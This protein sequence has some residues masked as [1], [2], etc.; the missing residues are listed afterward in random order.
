MTCN[1][2]QQQNSENCALQISFCESERDL[3]VIIQSN[4]VWNEHVGKPGKNIKFLDWS[5]MPWK[6]ESE[7]HDTSNKTPLRK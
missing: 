6:Q 1:D 3:G 7:K 5:L 2:H 4:H